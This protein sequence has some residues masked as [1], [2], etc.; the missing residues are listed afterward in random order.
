MRGVVVAVALVAAGCGDNSSPDTPA[1]VARQYYQ[2]Y[3]SADA[4]RVCEP[5]TPAARA[6]LAS[7]FA[8]PDCD[9][10][11]GRILQDLPDETKAVKDVEVLSTSRRGDTATVRVH[12]RRGND[13]E[14][15]LRRIAGRW[16]VDAG[17]KGTSWI[18]E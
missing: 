8:S 2:A 12:V 14:L 10:T 4:S 16:R 7:D 18:G 6:R 3:G 17:H 1:E 11:L 15:A 13:H 9:K 5:L